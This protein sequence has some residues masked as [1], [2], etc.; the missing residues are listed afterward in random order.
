MIDKTKIE[1]YLKQL[2]DI[3][4]CVT[5]QCGLESDKFTINLPTTKHGK[6]YLMYDKKSES[7][8]LLCEFCKKND[9]EFWIFDN[10]L[11]IRIFKRST[12]K[13]R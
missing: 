7:L 12:I 9:F 8:R 4:Y 13:E 6:R 10:P 3:G 2:K 11:Q 5:Y 1:D